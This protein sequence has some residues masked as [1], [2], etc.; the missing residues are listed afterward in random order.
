MRY[1]LFQFLT[2]KGDRL[3]RRL[4]LKM[5]LLLLRYLLLLLV[6]K[7]VVENLDLLL[8]GNKKHLSLFHVFVVG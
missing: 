8:S 4:E 2:L 3:L 5:F 7:C 6:G 1:F